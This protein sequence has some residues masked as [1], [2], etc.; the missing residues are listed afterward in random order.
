MKS[1]APA[2]LLFLSLVFLLPGLGGKNS[3]GQGDEVMHLLTVQSSLKSGSYL[4][5]EIEGQP[6]YY[7]PPLLFWTGM[8]TERIFGGGLFGGRISSVF[9]SAGTALLIYL[10]LVHARVDFRVAFFASLAYIL[11]VGTMKFA[12]LLMM[13][14][15]MAFAL[16]LIAFLLFRQMRTG[17]LRYALL[18]GLATGLAFLFKGPLFIV[19]TGLIYAVWAMIGLFRM[20]KRAAGWNWRGRSRVPHVAKTAALV[21][22]GSLV[23]PLLWVGMILGYAGQE[24]QVLLK[25]FFVVENFGKFAQENQN[26][27]RILAGWITYTFPWTILV[28]AGM[29]LVFVPQKLENQRQYIG[30]ILVL[31]VFVI[32]VF[33]ILP[34]RK[35]AY[36]GIPFAPFVF[37]GIPLLLKDLRFLER[38]ARWTVLLLYLISPILAFAAVMGSESVLG[39][40]VLVPALVA[41]VLEVLAR[42]GKVSGFAENRSLKIL[43]LSGSLLMLA[44]QFVLYPLL[45]HEVVPVGRVSSFGKEMCLVT[46]ETWDAMDLK[47]LRPDIDVIAT[48]PMSPETCVDGR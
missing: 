42:R 15:G 13:E 24:G 26:T 30:R 48:V 2:T 25:F 37:A 11:T 1:F 20:E 21:I 33:H 31:S 8:A 23:V 3:P 12:R 38:P 35:A 4:I 9:F 17:R 43:G 10:L 29:A 6:N 18:S 5:P 19:Y 39:L 41:L 28:L 32:M 27:L 44:L 14:Q 16:M 40:V 45:N 7:K 22:S 36:Y 34:H 47:G 46:G